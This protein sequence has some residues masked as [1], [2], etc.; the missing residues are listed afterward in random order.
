VKIFVSDDE[1]KEVVLNTL[2]PGQYFGEYA[3][4]DGGERSAS[5]MTLE[6]CQF[7]VLTSATFRNVLAKHPDIAMK[8]I[9]DLVSRVRGVLGDVKSFALDDVYGRIAKTLT[10]LAVPDG[11][12]KTSRVTHRLTHQDIADRVGASREMVSRIMKDLVDGGFISVDNRQIVIR[13]RL[14]D[15]Y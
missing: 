3:M 10:S 9:A 11:D 2:G 4:V 1:G 12:G 13:G 8:L 5:V 7:G 15:A 14:P 6:P